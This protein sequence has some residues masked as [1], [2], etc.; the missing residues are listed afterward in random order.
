MMLT[1]NCCCALPIQGKYHEYTTTCWSYHNMLM[2]LTSHCCCALP[3]QGKYHKY[4]TTCWWCSLVMLPTRRLTSHAHNSVISHDESCTANSSTL[5]RDGLD[6]H[7]CCALPIQG[8]YHEYT[9]CWW[10]SLVT[11][12]VHCLYKGSTEYTTTSWSYHN[13]LMMLTKSL[14]LCTTYTRGVPWVYH[15]MLMMLT[16]HVHNSSAHKPWS[17]LG[18]FPW[19]VV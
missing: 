7:C 13:M 5:R 15:N 9:T 1:S 10:C 19:W 2:M 16:S 11:A 6:T 8:K 14:L 3:I 12:A 18:D 17:Q 4:T